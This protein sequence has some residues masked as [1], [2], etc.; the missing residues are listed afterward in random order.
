MIYEFKIVK[1]LSFKSSCKSSDK[2][3]II[4]S[5]IGQII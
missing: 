4:F 1:H 5:I 3:I 2:L